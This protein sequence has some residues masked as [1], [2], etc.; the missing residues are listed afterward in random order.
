MLFLGI[1]LFTPNAHGDPRSQKI[2]TLPKK[3]SE[4]SGLAV[5]RIFKNRVYHMN[6]SGSKGVF[7]VSDLQG[8]KES[9]QKISIHKYKPKDMEDL[10]L[11][12]CLTN[13]S[14]LFIADIGNNKLKRKK[15][16]IIVIEEKE[17]KAHLFNWWKVEV[18]YLMK[19][20]V[21]Y[22]LEPQNAEAFAVHPNGD[23]YIVTK[24][25]YN[26]EI[27]YLPRAK[28]QEKS[29]GAKTLIKKGDLI[30][31][32]Y[33]S[34][35][36]ARKSLVTGMD[37]SPKG[38]RFLLLTYGPII[39]FYIDLSKEVPLE[40]GVKNGKPQFKVYNFPHLK[41]QEAISYL[42]DGSGFIY[43]SERKHGEKGQ[44]IL[45]K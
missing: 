1:I 38:D 28:W 10:S 16:K 6:D 5:S 14:C 17:W 27:Y 30:M 13:K 41:Q 39:E 29:A 24:K 12:P 31:K 34:I 26:C 15:L 21:R 25:R 20:S 18:D 36:S 2:G 32:N 9:L 22:P 7:Y 37:I 33:I 23:L 4:A 3:L 44:M 42:P 43:N 8:S 19:F 11:G 35:P 45:V 40:K